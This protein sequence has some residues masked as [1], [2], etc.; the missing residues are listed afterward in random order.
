MPDQIERTF[1]W[2]LSKLLGFI[3]VLMG[4]GLEVF[5]VIKDQ[6]DLKVFLGSVTAATVLVASKQANDTLRAKK[7]G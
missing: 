4:F 2:T 7:G 3:V 6:F 1:N 5:L